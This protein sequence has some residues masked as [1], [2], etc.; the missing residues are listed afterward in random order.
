MISFAPYLRS[1]SFSCIAE[2]RKVPFTLPGFAEIYFNRVQIR[3]NNLLP[4]EE[5]SQTTW[6]HYCASSC[7]QLTRQL[8]ESWSELR[9]HFPNGTTGKTLTY[10]AGVWGACAGFPMVYFLFNLL[11]DLRQPK[12]KAPERREF[13]QVINR[14][15]AGELESELSIFCFSVIQSTSLRICQKNP[16]KQTLCRALT[17][18]KEVYRWGEGCEWKGRLQPVAKTGWIFTG[19]RGTDVE[20]SGCEGHG[21][22]I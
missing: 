8:E 12:C 6:N 4:L 1:C 2:F 10:L 16:I 21:S 7:L 14:A 3:P 20:E 18:A 5:E 15:P 17:V 22:W 13:H 9:L 11:N 19:H